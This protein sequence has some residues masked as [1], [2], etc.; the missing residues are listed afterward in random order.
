MRAVR[1]PG[2][3]ARRTLGDGSAT[4]VTTSEGRGRVARYAPV[5]VVRVTWSPPCTVRP[6]CAAP[7]RGVRCSPSRRCPPSSPPR[8][9]PPP[10]PPPA[11]AAR[12]AARPTALV[13][14]P[15]VFGHRGASGY[16]P[17]HTLASYDLAIRMGADVIEPD[18]VST[19]DR[20]LVARH[21]NDITGTTDVADHPE[22]ADRKTTKID[23]RHR[24]DRLV[25]R[26]L[27][28]S[29]AAH[30]ARGGAAARRCARRTRST[31]AATGSRP[32][33]RSSTWRKAASARYGRTIG[34]RAG[35]QAPDLLRRAS[36]SRSRSAWS[37]RCAATASTSRRRRLR[38]VL[39]GGQPARAERAGSTCR[40]RAAHQRG[41]DRP[42]VRPR[43]R[44]ATRRPT[45]QMTSPAG[46]GRSPRTPTWSAR[47]RRRSS[48]A[49]RPATRARRRRWST[50]PT[51]ACSWCR[52]PSAPRTSSCRRSTARAAAPTRTPTAT[53]SPRSTSY[54]RAGV[55]GFFTDQAD[56]GVI[57]R[58]EFLDR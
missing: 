51:P 32:S 15:L 53:C 1:L 12:A 50:T 31:T 34:D 11:S 38:A 39:R 17:E 22:F 52:T 55:D 29:R 10:R 21:E 44:R 4:T 37:P 43:R 33:S 3:T 45:R 7:W 6:L 30:A 46:C 28:P 13:D 8:R 9:P 25:H 14:R 20:V 19:K 54:L 18:L 2:E 23:R 27:H 58:D 57:A 47:T 24:H 5:R 48:R 16:R 35:D 56:I 42:P 41:P 26:G 40:P 36:A 49:T